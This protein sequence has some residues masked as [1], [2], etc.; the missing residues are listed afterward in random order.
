MK[1]LYDKLSYYP[2]NTLADPKALYL[3]DT[4]LTNALRRV[5]PGKLNEIRKK[6]G[7]SDSGGYQIYSQGLNK[8]KNVLLGSIYQNFLKDPDFLTIGFLSN[9]REYRR[10][11]SNIGFCVDIPIDPNDSDYKYYY[12]M[13]ETIIARNHM[14]EIA[15]Q[16]CPKTNMAIVLHPRTPLEIE[17][18]FGLVSAPEILIYAYPART[19]L[20]Y[21]LGNAYVLSFL[22]SVGVR[23]IHFLGSSACTLI[24]LLAQA[25]VLNLFDRC[26]FDSL[27][28]NQPAVCQGYRYLNPETLKSIP[29][30]EPLRPDMNLLRA[31]R[32]HERFLF[33][34]KNQFNPPQYMQV[35]RWLGIVNIEAIKYFKNRMLDKLIIHGSFEN[36]F[37]KN[38]KYDSLIAAANLLYESQYYGHDFVKEKYGQN[39][40]NFNGIQ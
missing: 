12:I 7:M 23:H 30:R 14:L 24:A 3:S 20:K 32:S 16:I 39:L 27:T 38:K 29:K 2:V 40:N 19:K 21:A 17:D 11:N 25:V 26:S 15:K 35:K 36:I 22:H 18:Y 33:K 1:K 13:N 31:L 28:W 9:C 10:L 34:F 5:S 8:G 37:N 4:T 6:D